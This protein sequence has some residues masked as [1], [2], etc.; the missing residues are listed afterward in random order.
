MPSTRTFSG[1]TPEILHRMKE[2]GRAEY[3]IVYDPP[4][5]PVSTATSQTPLGECVVEFAH[6]PAKAELTLTL[7]KKPWLLPEG[8]LWS[9]FSE[10]LERCRGET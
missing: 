3:N 7:L 6:D 5:G 10:T 2:F 9:G 1:V 8:L 4:E